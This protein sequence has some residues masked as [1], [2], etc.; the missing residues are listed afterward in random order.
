MAYPTLLPL[1][2]TQGERA[3]EQ[4]MAHVGDEPLDVRTVK[5]AD[6][7][8]MVALPALAWEYGATYWEEGWTD[9][10]KRNAT[11]NAPAINKKRG[12]A[13]AV[14]QALAVVGREIEVIEWWQ[15]T[16]KAAPYTFRINIIG[17]SITP[18]EMSKTIY[19]ALDMKNGRSW[20][21]NINID[22][23]VLAG[24]TYISGVTV[25]RQTVVLQARRR[26]V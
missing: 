10:Q 5:N 14:K 16:P 24:T 15:E 23:P 7:C 20:L 4:V 11:K 9:E 2:S 17:D 22:G 8:P 13:W 19:Q 21:S 26:D 12:T 6:T 25:T 1:N 18:D 3:L